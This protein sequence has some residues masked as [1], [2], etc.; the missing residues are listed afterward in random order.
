VQYVKVQENSLR[1]QWC[2]R[3]QQN[4]YASPGIKRARIG[5]ERGEVEFVFAKA[6]EGRVSWSGTSATSMVFFV[7][8]GEWR[9]QFPTFA[10]SASFNSAQIIENKA[11]TRFKR[12]QAR[13]F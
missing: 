11:F 13:E 6:R 7:Q 5:A 1:N 9:S 12:Q 3:S 4:H 2:V 10:C 8:R